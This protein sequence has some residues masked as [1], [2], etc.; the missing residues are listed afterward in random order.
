MK[1]MYIHT[2]SSSNIYVY[3]N[4]QLRH[5]STFDGKNVYQTAINVESY[6]AVIWINIT[7]LV[8]WNSIYHTQSLESICIIRNNTDTDAKLYLELD[9]RACCIKYCLDHSDEYVKVNILL[10]SSLCYVYM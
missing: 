2:A 10:Y 5:F 4:G 3:L 9:L 6:C 7:Q 1:P 8:K